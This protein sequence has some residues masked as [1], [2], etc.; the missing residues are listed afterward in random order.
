[1]RPA[2]ISYLCKIP[3]GEVESSS[4]I[5]FAFSPYASPV[6]Q[7]YSLN[8]RQSDAG[9]FEIVSAVKAL[10]HTEQL[11]YVFHIKTNS[12]VFDEAEHLHRPSEFTAT[13]L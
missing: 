2:P 8:S 3:E 5:Y 12:I 13:T 1:M 11:I 7:D 9:S 6:T 4:L 10:K